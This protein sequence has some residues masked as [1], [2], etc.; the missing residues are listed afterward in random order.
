MDDFV[1]FHSDKDILWFVKYEITKYLK[2]LKL[3]LHE[4]KCRIFKT[5]Q[6]TPFLG[7]TIADNWRR[8][9]RKNVIRFK[10]K[11]RLFQILYGYDQ[12]E[13]RHIHQSIQSWIGHAK[14]ADTMQLRKLI[15]PE[16]V[17]KRNS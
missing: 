8:L 13:W 17:F 1:V 16:I 3:E 4:N 11:L 5:S 9:N 10:R 15:L 12:I 14:H 7:F 6:G 2:S